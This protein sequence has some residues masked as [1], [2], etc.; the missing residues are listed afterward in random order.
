MLLPF[1]PAARLTLTRGPTP[2][3]SGDRAVWGCHPKERDDRRVPL[4]RPLAYF[5]ARAA[6]DIPF[7]HIDG[8]I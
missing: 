1:L 2:S 3:L 4:S 8:M 6:C 5:S 7:E